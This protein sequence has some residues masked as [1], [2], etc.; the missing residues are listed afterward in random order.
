MNTLEIDNSQSSDK[1]EKIIGKEGQIGFFK[2]DDYVI[3][4]GGKTDLFL[5]TY[6]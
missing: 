4:P 3:T 6:G 2:V 5:K 1:Q